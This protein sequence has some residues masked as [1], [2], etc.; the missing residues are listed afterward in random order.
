MKCKKQNGCLKKALLIAEKRRE[1]KGKRETGKIYPSEFQRV[2][3]SSK[4]R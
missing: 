3:K 4:E 2:P 1:M